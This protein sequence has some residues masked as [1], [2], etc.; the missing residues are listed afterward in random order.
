MTRNTIV[1]TFVAALGALGGCVVAVLAAAGVA[2][3]GSVLIRRGADVVELGSGPLLG[4]AIALAVLAALLAVTSVVLSLVAWI[5]ALVET[6]RRTDKALFIA[7]LV[8]GV[9]GMILV[10]DLVYVVATGTEPVRRTDLADRDAVA[11]PVRR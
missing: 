5:A 9:L 11:E 3:S 2:L 4:V 6:G 8:V 10:A 7:V 1:R